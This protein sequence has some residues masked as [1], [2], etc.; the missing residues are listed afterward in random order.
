MGKT[1]TDLLA[2]WA[3]VLLVTATCQAVADPVT[4]SWADLQKDRPASC[5]PLLD[6]YLK[7]PKCTQQ[8]AAARLLSSRYEECAPGVNSLDGV[9]IRIAGYIHPL[10]FKFKDVKT[11]LIIPPLRRDCR[12]PPPPLPDQVVFVDFPDGIDVTADPVWVTGVLRVERS[13]TH[14]ATA[15]YSL[16]AETITP[17]TIPD[18]VVAK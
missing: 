5:K 3:F 2:P 14:L 12:H 1:K 8:S 13:S 16:Q 15:N 17:A 10:E 4:I 6:N 18:V 11:F 9:A 7:Q